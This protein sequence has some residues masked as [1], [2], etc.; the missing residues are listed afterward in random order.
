M[1][2][3]NVNIPFTQLAVALSSL[4]L[5]RWSYR[6]ATNLTFFF[7]SSGIQRYLQPKSGEASGGS[8]Q[9]PWALIT[10]S[11]AGLGRALAFS[12]ASHGFNIIVHGSN[13]AKL[14]TVQTELQAAH[15]GRSV[16]TLQ[17]DSRIC[18]QLSGS[19]L[20]EKLDGVA[21]SFQDINLR[22]LIN[23]VGMPQARPELRPPFDAIDTFSYDELL[24]NASGNALFPLI[25]TRALYPLL[26]HNGPAAIINIGSWISMGLPLAPSYGPAK[27][28]LMASTAELRLENRI[29]GRDIEVLGIKV[30]GVTGTDTIHEPP[31]VLIPDA[32]TY[33]RAII[34]S[35]GCGYPIVT[36]W[37]PHAMFFSVLGLLPK[38]IRD[39]IFCR[40]IE[41]VRQDYASRLKISQ[42]KE[43]KKKSL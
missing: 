13:A 34:K 14:L 12:L 17:L 36:P 21:R 31:S 15:P 25:L 7:R 27:A 8:T 30:L 37:L 39:L 29:E 18:T 28:F 40:M 11:S 23:N 19:M 24:Q 3:P 26:I 1:T 22:I 43:E 16:R 32:E 33:A 41:G 5:A 2:Q 10:G 4:V 42:T 6:L 38:G 35:I 9:E 20:A